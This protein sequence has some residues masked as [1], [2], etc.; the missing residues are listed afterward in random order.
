MGKS[1]Y[2][3][4]WRKLSVPSRLLMI[5]LAAPILALNFWT[6]AL[7]SNYFG[8]LIGIVVVA[9]L[10]AFLLNYPVSW[11]VQWGLR[12]EPAS[13]MVA[14]LAIS[15]LLGL[16][17]VLFP[18]AF[19]Q[20]QQL[21]NRLPDW[22]E[23]GR[24]QL[25]LLSQQ[26]E[27]KGLSMNL[28]VLAAQT[29]DRLEGQ[30]QALTKSLLNIALGTVSSVLDILI[31]VLVTVILTFYLL[32][33]G[34]ELW[35]N[36]I[37]W[38]PERSQEPVSEILRS[39]FQNYF[40]GQ[41]LFGICMTAALVPTFLILKVPFGLLFGL[42]IGTMAL[43]PFGG[44]VG[45]ILVT[46]LVALQ[47]I[48][49]G[50]KLLAAAVVVQQILDNLVAP[51]ILGT[52]T[53]LNPAWVFISI[54]IG[55]KAGGLIGVVIAVPMAVVIKTALVSLRSR[56]VANDPTASEVAVVATNAETTPQPVPR[57]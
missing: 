49:L 3:Y 18:V 53:G 52:M 51:R 48:W 29:F 50:L 39:S 54:L 21:T 1:D 17:V 25:I 34:D 46:S 30:L 13:I 10:L 14:L 38:L 22:F 15:L 55:A 5:G 11:C 32:Q 40:I 7:I 57:S 56:M 23:S 37:N 4:W 42:T 44:T 8:V 6:L 12:R 36:L 47:N 43:I 27:E 26:V 9:S 19:N 2:F 20:A 16:A 31:D 45:I 35:G 28:D 33:H 41:L 24:Q